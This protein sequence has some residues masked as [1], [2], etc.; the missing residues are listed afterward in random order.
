MGVDRITGRVCVGRFVPG[1]CVLGRRIGAEFIEGR[2]MD[3]KACTRTKKDLIEHVASV[4]GQSRTAVRRTIQVAFDHIVDEL[5]DGNRL[6][7]R[8]FGVFVSKYR[9]GRI[10]QNPKTLEPV[11]V[12][13]RRTVKFKPSRSMRDR[14]K[15]E[16]ETSSAPET[17][18]GTV[19]ADHALHIEK[20]IEV[21]ATTSAPE[22]VQELAPEASG[23]S[24]THSQ[25][26]TEVSAEMLNEPPVKRPA[27]PTVMVHS[28][29]PVQASNVSI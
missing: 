26:P 29:S 15:I 20:P 13:P 24:Q 9:P 27:K 23:T 22:V 2:S 1:S 11:D 25:S 17:V 6:E 28:R 4:T 7:F 5:A 8:D 10:A 3:S 14:L 12:P 21:P 19:Q 18:Q 16:C